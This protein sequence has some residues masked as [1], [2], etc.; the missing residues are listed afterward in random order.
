MLPLSVHSILSRRPLLKSIK[1][2][3]KVKQLFCKKKQSGKLNIMLT[4]ILPRGDGRIIR[5]KLGRG[6]ILHQHPEKK[7][8]ARVSAL[9]G[10]LPSKPSGGGGGGVAKGMPYRLPLQACLAASYTSFSSCW[11]V[12]NHVRNHSN[13][14]RRA[15]SV[16]Y[17]I[18]AFSLITLPL[19]CN[20]SRL[21]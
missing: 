12:A 17:S 5:G 19:H 3:E 9:F 1:N 8:K 13:Y 4:D 20:L 16:L 10:G 14:N 6:F 11:F 7:P 21:I 15:S 18:K 2:K